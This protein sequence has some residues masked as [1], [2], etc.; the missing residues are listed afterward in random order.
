MC[1]GAEIAGLA[2][3]AGGGI[4]QASSADDAADK[5]QIIINQADEQTKKL[6]Q[7][8]Q[9]ITTDFADKTFN[10]AT[11]DQSYEA[12]ATKQEG[13]LVD[14]L[15]KANAGSD[16]E[17]TNA[18]QGTLSDDY[19]RARGTATANATEDILKRAKLMARNGAGGLLYNQEA[20]NG[21]QLSSDIA[22]VDSKVN[23]VNRS[24]NNNLATAGNKGSLIGGILSG[25]SPL[26]ASKGS[27]I[28]KNLSPSAS[29]PP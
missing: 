21:G 22:G 13:S 14:A 17:V 15:L 6:N 24:T 16:G 27:G 18:T 26:L 12:A 23:S 19:T 7:Q 2:L 3:A 20:L 1:T 9:Q 11:R 8:R 4:M 5:Q 10:P 25:A 28:I 29:V